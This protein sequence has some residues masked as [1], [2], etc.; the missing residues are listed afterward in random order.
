MPTSLTYKN[1]KA[2]MDMTGQMN[3]A[4]IKAVTGYMAQNPDQNFL[5]AQAAV[6]AQFSGMGIDLSKGVQA[7][8]DLN[9]DLKFPQ[10]IG[11]G[12]SYEASDNFKLALDVEWINWAKLLI[13]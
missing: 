1:G 12:T 8:Y 9:V 4:F 2:S 10:S 7:N 11:F 5:Q 13:R 6:M 3:D